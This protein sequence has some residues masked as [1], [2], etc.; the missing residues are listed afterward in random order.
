MEIVTRVYAY[1]TREAT[2]PCHALIILGLIWLPTVT[3][4]SRVLT[5]TCPPNLLLVVLLAHTI[6]Q[7]VDF[8]WFRVRIILTLILGLIILD[9]LL[10]RL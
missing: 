1:V 10:I 4:E 7:V 6:I 3:K 5:Q 9:L 8:I 2:T